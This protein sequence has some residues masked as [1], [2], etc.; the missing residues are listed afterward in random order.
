MVKNFQ[1]FC[2]EL[3]RCGFSMGGGNDKGIFAIIDYDWKEQSNIE[4]PVMWH[5]G[6]PETDPWEWRIRVLRERSDI[7]YAKVFFKASGYITKPWYADFICARRGKKDYNSMYSDGEIT[8]MSAAVY[9][10]I[11][12]YDA[13]PMHEIKSLGGFSGVDSAKFDKAITELQMKM[14]IT[15]C[16][17]VRKKNKNGEE[18]GW[19]STIM[20]TVESFWKD[21]A[22]KALT[23]DPKKSY[24]KIKEQILKLN[25]NAAESK[26]KKFI[27]G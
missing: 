25:P 16:G 6:D 1:E 26:I 18:Y 17:A 7:A 15:M 3:I 12:R 9:D 11:S 21:E 14:L 19:N 4:T 5:T 8:E 27:L 10:I 22:S 20:C 23:L 24:D 2:S 13:L